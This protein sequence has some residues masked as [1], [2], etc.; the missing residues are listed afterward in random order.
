MK[1]DNLERFILEH[2]EEFDAAQP[3]LH[4]WAGI[5]RQLPAAT[6]QASGPARIV[7]LFTR[8]KY[9]AA[10][11]ALLVIGFTAGLNIARQQQA[12]PMA[13]IE[14]VNPD[15]RDAEKYYTGQINDKLQLLA[16]YDADN[17][18]VLQDLA[19]VD[20][21]M[22]ELKQELSGAP[23]GA[24]EQIVAD[25]IRSYRNKVAIL[26]KVLESISTKQEY[27][28]KTQKNEIGI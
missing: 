7:P 20:E 27:Q 6:P 17:E 14:R 8:L 13:E 11:A 24:E 5:E 15:F 18:A 28:S 16:T 1:H 19:Q 2:R 25:L 26:E 9:A 10:V 3:P 12:S 22:E 4:L 23:A 21:I